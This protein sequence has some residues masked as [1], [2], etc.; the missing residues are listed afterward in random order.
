MKNPGLLVIIV[1][2]LLYVAMGAFDSYR[3]NDQSDI[4]VENIMTVQT[5]ASDI[6]VVEEN[7]TT[8]QTASDNGGTSVAGAGLSAKAIVR[9]SETGYLVLLRITNERSNKSNLYV[10]ASFVSGGSSFDCPEIPI[11]IYPGETIVIPLRSG[12]DMVDMIK[13]DNSSFIFKVFDKENKEEF[14]SS[15]APLPKIEDIELGEDKNINFSSRIT[16]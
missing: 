2:V 13:G 5:V 11:F 14:L 1:F 9:S 8:A 3:T 12:E 7:I 4:P 10:K 15:S 6:S 16:P